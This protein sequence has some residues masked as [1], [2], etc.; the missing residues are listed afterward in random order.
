MIVKDEIGP[1]NLEQVQM[2]IA[3][4]KEM[5][6]PNVVKIFEFFESKRYFHIAM[7]F[8]KGQRLF[9]QIIEMGGVSE[10]RTADIMQQLLS[11]LKYLHAKGVVHRDIKSENMMYDGRRIKI[12]DFGTSRHFDPLKHMGELKGTVYYVAPEVISKKY[13][14]KCDIWSAG[15]LLFILLTGTP[16]FV[17]ERDKDIFKNILREN[18][19]MRI[20]DEED[21]SEAVKD[22]VA[23]MLTYEQ[24]DRPSAEELLSHPWFEILKKEEDQSEKMENSNRLRKPMAN[25]ELFDLRNRLQEGVF[26]YLVSHM[27][28]KREQGEL[29][30]TFRLLD[31]NNDGEISRGE[32]MSGFRRVGRVYSKEEVDEIFDLVDTDGSGT[33]SF[34]EYVAAAIS[35]E[36]L[37]ARDRLEKVFRVFDRDKSGTISLEEF[38][39]VFHGR[40]YIPEEE[41]VGLI[42]EADMNEDGELDFEEFQT[43]MEKMIVR[44]GNGENVSDN[45]SGFFGLNIRGST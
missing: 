31:T 45:G 4:L 38:Q 14:E 37:L 20:E 33:I 3:I 9:N 36:K 27:V 13:T 44:K 6:H 40:H 2:E 32:L 12:I 15:V 29:A 43:V 7:E 39:Y 26:Y 35:K 17:G 22:L 24:E 25:L 41:L 19:S 11:A 18:Y 30:R 34:T 21:L 16:P 1:E 5:D 42:E 8:C 23:K 10:R 28:S